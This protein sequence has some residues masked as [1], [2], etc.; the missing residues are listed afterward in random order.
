MHEIN[1]YIIERGA[2]GKKRLNVL[3]D[4]LNPYSR[5]LIESEG[6]IVGKNFFDVGCGGGNVSLMAAQMVGATGT[7]L[8]VDF[9]EEIVQLAASDAQEIG[10]NNITFRVQSAYEIAEENSFDIAYSR[11]LL[12]HLTN[13]AEVI[14]NM[15]RALKPGGRIIVED[16]DF[17]GHYCCP[18]RW[19]F[20]SY[21][22]LFTTA[23]KNNG[24]D[25]NIGLSLF[26]LF[27]Q[28]DL[29]QVSFDVV[30]PSFHT[31]SGKWMAYL[32]MDKIRNA[33]LQQGLASENEISNILSDLKAFIEDEG[34]IISLPRIFRV[35]G[36]K[37]V[38]S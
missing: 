9:D 20:T 22:N 27:R 10:L 11:F 17:S 5:Q 12:S 24:Q 6:S 30:Q 18:E 35:W 16:I 32:T 1:P 21:I 37:N 14:N 8:A 15:I 23:A 13:P 33:V 34:T 26:S 7:V 28:T 36:Y 3:A 38:T 4:I 25:A 2:E 19:S 29:T 31:G